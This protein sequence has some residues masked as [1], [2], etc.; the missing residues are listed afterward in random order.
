VRGPVR[1]VFPVPVPVPVVA[2]PM[3]RECNGMLVAADPHAGGE[4]VRLWDG[5]GAFQLAAAV[6]HGKDLAGAVRA[7][8]LDNGGL[9]GAKGMANLRE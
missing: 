7:H 6:L 5:L 9:G 1:V 8:R 4:L 2:V 3:L